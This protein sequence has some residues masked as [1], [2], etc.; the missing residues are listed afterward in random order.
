MPEQQQDGDGKQHKYSNL[1]IAKNLA[2]LPKYMTTRQKRK[3]HRRK[4]NKYSALHTTPQTEES[5]NGKHVHDTPL[6][7]AAKQLPKLESSASQSSMTQETTIAVAES[8]V[9]TEPRVPAISNEMI[10]IE[11]IVPTTPPIVEQEDE[12][13][14]TVVPEIKEGKQG[15]LS[16]TTETHL[17]MGGAFPLRTP[18][19]RYSYSIPWRTILPFA[20]LTLLF[21]NSLLLWQDLTATHLYVNTLDATNGRI[22]SQQDLGGYPGRVRLTAPVAGNNNSTSTALGVYDSGQG[23]TQQLLTLQNTTSNIALQRSTSLA[24]GAITRDTLGR[25]LVESANGLQV[26]TQNG[27]VVWHIEGQQPTRGVHPFVPASDASTVYTVASVTHSQVAAYTLETGHLRWTHILPDTLAYAPPFVVD[28]ETLYIASDSTIFALNIRDGSVQ[29]KQPYAA[30]TLLV[31]NVGQQHLLLALS[32]QGIQALQSTTGKVVWSFYGDPSVSTVPTQFYQGVLGTNTNT[33]YA[34]GV[35]WLMPTV[36][37][38]VRLYAIDAATGSMHWS[39]QIASGPTSVDTGRIFQPLF[40]RDTGTVV[41]QHALNSNQLALAAYDASDGTQRW[42]TAIANTSASSPA[43][44]WLTPHT[45]AIF[46]AQR[47]IAQ[48]YSGHPLCTVLLFCFS[49]LLV[50]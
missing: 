24:N 41:I 39:Q 43:L 8:N 36:R 27:Q 23:G 32:S 19:P 15:H 20:L 3:H 48:R 16:H 42:N 29:W 5:V 38:E 47:Q 37:E 34:T 25:L 44:F 30:R 33:V 22:S 7:S 2:S 21:I 1:L 35:V 31:E 11:T 12:G 4:Y 10:V 49:L 18:L 40:D 6:P 9:E 26:V 13:V 50:L 46:L 28:G 17:I 45:L 14:V